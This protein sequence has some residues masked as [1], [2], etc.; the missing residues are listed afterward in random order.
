MQIDPSKIPSA[1]ALIAISIVV[2][3]LID[4]YLSRKGRTD[5]EAELLALRL[6][7]WGTVIGMASIA[8]AGGMT[9]GG[10]APQV[11]IFSLGSPISINMLMMGYSIQ[12]NLLKKR[13]AASLAARSIGPAGVRSNRRR[14]GRNTGRRTRSRAKTRTN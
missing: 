8:S 11:V 13:M 5:E 6:N 2:S 12:R 14:S 4:I 7:H 9:I 10:Y 3:I 1:L